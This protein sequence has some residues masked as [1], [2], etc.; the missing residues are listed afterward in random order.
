MF[1]LDLFLSVL[2]WIF[3]RA[4]RRQRRARRS[5]TRLAGDR[6]EAFALAFLERDGFSTLER[7]MADSRG[8]LDLVGRQRGFDGVVVVEVRSRTEGS[9]VDPRDTVRRGKQR[10]VVRAAM[11]L[12]KHRGLRG[13]VRYDIVGVWLNAEGEPVRAERFV[14]AFGAKVL[15]TRR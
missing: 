10:R 3:G 13:P 1:I 9:P 5:A 7:N 2:D 15:R 12:L 11:R 4:F 8:E 14:D 6:A